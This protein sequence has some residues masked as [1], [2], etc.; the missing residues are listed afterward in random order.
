[1]SEGGKQQWR[2]RV[3]FCERERGR[4]RGDRAIRER[5]REREKE[6]ERERERERRKFPPRRNEGAAVL[7]FCVLVAIHFSSSFFSSSFLF[8]S[9][10]LDLLFLPSTSFL[11]CFS[12]FSVFVLGLLLYFL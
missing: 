3:Y 1:M 11:G 2:K 7:L 8:V 6:R 4:R 10:S 5:E 9:T 12:S